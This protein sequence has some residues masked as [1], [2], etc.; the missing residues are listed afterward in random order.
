[1]HFVC[2]YA[3]LILGNKECYIYARS[4]QICKICSLLLARREFGILIRFF[5][6]NK[7]R[8]SQIQRLAKKGVFMKKLLSIVAMLLTL[9]VSLTACKQATVFEA[10]REIGTGVEAVD[11]SDQYDLDERFKCFQAFQLDGD[12]MLHLNA[13]TGIVS[14]YF[15]AS[16]NEDGSTTCALTGIYVY[17][18]G[19]VAFGTI[20][21]ERLVE[22]VDKLTFTLVLENGVVTSHDLPQL[23]VE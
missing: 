22:F 18:V 4:L 17:D 23:I 2:I 10:I 15:I 20:A 8:K 9:L 7:I 11:H 16:E 21:S 14:Y 19:A 5:I 3:I 12:C 1:M 13:T 6:Y